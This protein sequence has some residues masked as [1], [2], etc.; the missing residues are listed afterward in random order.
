MTET[1]QI[2][3]FISF[4]VEA[5]P[6]RATEN[7]LERLV[8]GQLAGGE[9]G[10]RRLSK[11]LSMHRLKG[12]FLLDFGMC[13]LYGDKAVQQIA[14]FLLEE[15][16]E[17]HAH[18]HSEWIVRKWGLEGTWRGPLGMDRI[19]QSLSDALMQYT[20]WKYESLTGLAPKVFR[21]GGY[22]FSDKTITAAKRSGFRLLSN[23]NSSRH[24]ASWTL[25]ECTAHNAPFRWNN[26]LLELPVDFSPEPL[27]FDWGKYIGWYERARTRKTEK[28]FN[29]VLHSWSLLKR[30]GEYFD[31][32]AAEHEERL[33]QI[34]EHLQTHTTPLGYEE[35][36]QRREAE[37]ERLP[38]VDASL[39]TLPVVEVTTSFNTCNICGFGFVKVQESDTC[40]GCSSRARHR[41]LKDALSRLDRPFLG[42]TVLANY[43]NVVEVR[44]LLRGA[45]TL[46]NFDVR[47]VSEVELQ[48]D[49]QDMSAVRSGSIDVFWA[50][51]VLNHVKDDE[52]ALREI[53]RVLKPGGCAC[54][55]VPYREGVPTTA[56]SDMTEHYGKG[57]LDQYAVGT[58]RRYGLID[59]LALFGR[60]FDVETE[61]G[62]DPVTCQ[63]ML[64]FFLKKR[65]SG[66][67][68]APVA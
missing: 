13:L 45:R 61:N 14:Q 43:A 29:L 59:A 28:T 1:D 38:S 23:Y 37:L 35:Y 57:A 20:A 40:P 19:D 39:C 9:Y 10:I 6:G 4:D 48:M 60:Y 21:A 15:G 32:Y 67:K 52:Q 65:A 47:P 34:C 64:I 11:V 22:L 50:V 63:S 66:R 46:L 25:P 41:Q 30:N 12:N 8:W 18:L 58:F 16:H 5:L 68:P 2:S 42:K 36:L 51:H 31:A 54:L 49:I 53:Q 26:Q 55:T 7:L 56:L 44:A 27:S 24:A 62:F 3:S 17:V 33:H